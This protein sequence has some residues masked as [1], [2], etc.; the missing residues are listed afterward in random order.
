M[1]HLDRAKAPAIEQSEMNQYNTVGSFPID[2]IPELWRSR[3][4]TIYFAQFLTANL[5]KKDR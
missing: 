1:L 4:V 3:K 5:K 2:S